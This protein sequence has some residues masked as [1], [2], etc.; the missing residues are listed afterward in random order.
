M[1]RPLRFRVITAKITNHKGW[2]TS[3]PTKVVVG[4]SSATYKYLLS[5]VEEHDDLFK[6]IEMAILGSNYTEALALA[7]KGWQLRGR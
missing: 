6:Q 1:K 5:R 7:R 4:D 3:K 2:T